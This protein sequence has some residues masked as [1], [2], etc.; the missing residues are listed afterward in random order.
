MKCP[1][2]GKKIPSGSTVCPYC[3]VRKECLA[4]ASDL[5]LSSSFCPLCGSH[6][7]VL[8]PDPDRMEKGQDQDFYDVRDEEEALETEMMRYRG[9]SFAMEENQERIISLTADMQNRIRNR[10]MDQLMISEKE[11]AEYLISRFEEDRE[12][13]DSLRI[14]KPG[15]AG[16]PDDETIHER[17]EKKIQELA[18]RILEDLSHPE[19]DDPGDGDD[20]DERFEELSC[21]DAETLS[22]ACGFNAESGRFDSRGIGFFESDEGWD[23]RDLLE[24]FSFDLEEDTVSSPGGD[25]T[26]GISYIE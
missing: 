17:I 4:C 18:A 5:I 11:L 14:P 19:P 15:Q 23:V 21:Y 12:I 26:C 8:R 25:L 13:L 22:T 3:G 24:D 1:G 20:E 9:F 10:I 2:C 6:F 7:V 16:D